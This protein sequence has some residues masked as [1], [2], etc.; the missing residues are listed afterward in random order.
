MH[1]KSDQCRSDKHRAQPLKNHPVSQSGILDTESPLIR[2]SRRGGVGWEPE[3]RP[4]HLSF[5]TEYIL[6]GF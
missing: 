3:N 1:L 5:P 6:E 2:E 4:S